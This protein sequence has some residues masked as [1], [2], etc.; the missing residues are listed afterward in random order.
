MPNGSKNALT[1]DP[2]PKILQISNKAP[3]PANDGS[4][5]AVYNMA[6]GLLE[7]NCELVLLCINTKKHFKPDSGIPEA[8][9]K[10][11][12]YRSVYANTNTSIPGALL[13]LFSRQ[14]YFVSRFR[15]QAFNEV[16]IETLRQHQFDLVQLEGVF[17]A[18]YIDT[19][20]SYS[21]AKIVL[22][23]HN[24][25][26]YIWSRHI[27]LEKNPLKKL[28]LML[29]NRRLKRFELSALS[30]VDAVVPITRT[31]AIELP[32]LGCMLPCFPCI[33]GVDVKAYQALAAQARKPKTVFYFGSMDWMPNIEAVLWF[34]THCWNDIHK[35]VPEARLVV[36][37]KDMPSSIKKLD[38]P[39]LMV[40]E[41]VPDAG[42]FYR[43]HE[44]MVVPLWSG[45]G[46]RIKIIEGMAYGKAIISTSIGA[47]GIP[48][49][50]GKHIRIA[51]TAE[52]FTDEVVR[53]L[54]HS[55]ERKALE[56]AAAAF[57][58]REFDNVKVV[59]G[60]LNFYKT[61]LNG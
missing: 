22:R 7:N 15:I 9:R 60:L 43:Q 17:M 49:E 33:T 16:L 27:L 53:L 3:Y 52:D 24:I 48:A 21:K 55:E 2:L 46:L 61:L 31:D 5:I 13:N 26:H 10:T 32:K 50:H 12:H 36:A 11:S 58:L 59:A 51:D 54:R 47:E 19:I 1:E 4:S 18:G 8:F 42:V 39:N 20:R 34:T 25:E 44:V 41:N 57:A 29:Q 56:S 45:S 14:S 28:Y 40:I 6:K 37:G 35:A 23:A 38:A 30:A